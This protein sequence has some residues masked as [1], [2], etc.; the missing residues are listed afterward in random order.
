M[1]MIS[2][3]RNKQELI[4]YINLGNK[5]KYLHFWGNQPDKDNRMTKSCFSQWYESNF[6][7]DGIAYKTAEHFM[8]AKKAGL[9]SD[10]KSMEKI[11]SADHPGEAKKLGREVIGFNE[12]IWLEKR[13]ELVVEGNAAK[14]LQN[15]EMKRFLMGTGDR[16]LVEASPVDKIWGVGLAESDNKINDPNKWKGLNLLGFALMEVRG[17]IIKNET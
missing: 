5:V 7:V 17:T 14:F 13:F 2:E 16:I 6:E 8:M 10:T 1:K 9:F 4:K 3:I 11:I 15:N 12:K